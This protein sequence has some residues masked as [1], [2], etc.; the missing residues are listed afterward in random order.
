MSVD[1]VL[2]AEQRR[3]I[4]NLVVGLGYEIRS[5]RQ[6]KDAFSCC[7][8]IAVKSY[9]FKIMVW[10]KEDM[11]TLVVCMETF[12]DSDYEDYFR[13]YS[14][15]E[16][17]SI[18]TSFFKDNI[19]IKAIQDVQKSNKQGYKLKLKVMNIVLATG[20]FNQETKPD[21][22]ACC[23]LELKLKDYE[24]NS[25]NS[26]YNSRNIENKTSY[27]SDHQSL[28]IRQ[29]CFEYVSKN[30]HYQL[31]KME[32]SPI[33]E[34]HLEKLKK[35]I[36]FNFIYTHAFLKDSFNSFDT[37]C[38]DTENYEKCQLYLDQ[39]LALEDMMAV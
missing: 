36:L 25:L 22:S 6:R 14:L 33:D 2:S 1:F 9:N 23:F 38:F 37:L 13:R 32:D 24:R 8:L 7:Y 39:H 4:R 3:N 19:V 16:K 11:E 17:S 30:K 27:I 31:S 18:L 10:R 26:S 5:F 21:L 28:V 15:I 20:N 35:K 12:N 29:T 34:E